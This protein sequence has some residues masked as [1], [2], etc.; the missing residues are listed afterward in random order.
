MKFR[1][2]IVL[3]IVSA[4]I[5]ALFTSCA[6]DGGAA[7]AAPAPQQGAADGPAQAGDGEP[8]GTVPGT[9]GLV[10]AAGFPIVNENITVNIMTMMTPLQVEWNDMMIWEVYE[11]MTGITVNFESVPSEFVSERRNLIMAAGGDLP[12]AFM[13]MGFPAAEVSRFGAQ[14][15][16]IPLGDL[17]E[18][19]AP[20]FVYQM[21]RFPSIRAGL[22]MPDGNIYSFTYVLGAGAVTQGAYMFFNGEVLDI[23]GMDVPETM[24]E[25]REFL[26][27]SIEVNFNGQN[28]SIG[29]ATSDVRALDR[30][31]GPFFGLYNRGGAHN[32]VDIDQDG[33][34]RF[35]PTSQ[36]YKDMLMFLN[37]LYEEGLLDPEIYM[38]D[39]MTNLIAMGEQGR[40]MSFQFINAAIIGA[41]YGDMMRGMTVPLTYP[42]MGYTE[43]RWAQSPPFGGH[44]FVISHTSNYPE[45]LVRWVDYFYTPE[46]NRMFFMGFEGITWEYDEYGR[47]QYNDY[48]LNHPD[49]IMFE[50]VLGAYVPWAGGGNPSIADDAYFRGGEM[51]PITMATAEAFYPYRL[52]HIWPSFMWPAEVADDM[53]AISTDITTYLNENRALFI[54]SRRSFDEWDD[55]V[56]GFDALRLE[57]F[58]EIYAQMIPYFE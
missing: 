25:F 44:V 55:F 35:Q 17:M 22:T 40:L 26:R 10:N 45:A 58:M 38:Q 6:G 41:R 23:L 31:F 32:L 53:A 34:I 8:E 12:D 27:R 4:A 9:G 30:L 39:N 57:R 29:F 42:S 15:L 18:S 47:P 49:G 13:G 5:F 46:G 16:L 28:N 36:N 37:S 43:R 20:A 33:N 24:E 56:R 14:G 19:L 3:M 7:P 1:K 54:T 48:V 11:E 2:I 50:Q 21:N 51:Q 52:P